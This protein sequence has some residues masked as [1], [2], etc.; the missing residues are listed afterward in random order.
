M[1]Y[2]TRSW[3]MYQLTKKNKEL[4][5]IELDF[6]FQLD[7]NSCC[8]QEMGTKLSACDVIFLLP[9]KW[10]KVLMLFSS[11]LFLKEINKLLCAN[12]SWTSVWYPLEFLVL[13]TMCSIGWRSSKPIGKQA[14]FWKWGQVSRKV[15]EYPYFKL[16]L[17]GR[18]ACVAASPR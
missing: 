11:L 17:A 15:F 13:I 1:K 12:Y 16:P 8:L 18:F 3:L 6:E 5:F 10:K 7:L 2:K 9:A 4:F 14:E